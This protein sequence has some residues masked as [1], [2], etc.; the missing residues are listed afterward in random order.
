MSLGWPGNA[1]GSPRGAGGGVWG[2]GRLGV[3]AES[4][5]PAT[6]S[7]ISGRRRLQGVA[8]QRKNILADHGNEPTHYT[9][10]RERETKQEMADNTHVILLSECQFKLKEVGP[11]TVCIQKDSKEKKDVSTEPSEADVNE[12]AG[13]LED[14]IKEVKKEKKESSKDKKESKKDSSKEA[15]EP[16]DEA[17]KKESSASKEKKEKEKEKEGKESGDKKVS[18]KSSVKVKDKKKEAGA[19]E[20]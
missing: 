12:E 16:K 17:K 6:R 3:S 2:E 1:L 13:V 4:A 11:E 7:R 15:K 20:G 9:T 18:R 5:A 8:E 10:P 14:P 19:G